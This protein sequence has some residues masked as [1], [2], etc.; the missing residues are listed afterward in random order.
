MT[1]RELRAEV[2]LDMAERYIRDS[3]IPLTEIAD[4]L[5]FGELSN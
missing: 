2:R 1:F 5:G 3:D 4:I